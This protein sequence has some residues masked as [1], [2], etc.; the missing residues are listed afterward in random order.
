MSNPANKCVDCESTETVA[1]VTGPF[2]DDYFVCA[3][4]AKQH[5]IHG[6]NPQVKKEPREVAEKLCE[7]A[8]VPTAMAD[9]MLVVSIS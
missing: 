4:H 1:S 3:E 2:G 6:Y 5:G 8:G 9:K 7:Q